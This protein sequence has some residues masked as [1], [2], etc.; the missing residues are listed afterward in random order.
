MGYNRQELYIYIYIGFVKHVYAAFNLFFDYL[1]SLNDTAKTK[2][3]MQIA[4]ENGLEFLD[5]ELKIVESKIN[6]DV[7]SKPTNRF[8]YMLLWT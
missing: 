1:N 8:M 3:T 6:V 5:L 7:Y 4:R 2:F